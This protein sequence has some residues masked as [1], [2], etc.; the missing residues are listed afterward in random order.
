MPAGSWNYDSDIQ[1]TVPYRG[2]KD[3]STI[4]IFDTTPLSDRYFNVLEFPDRFTAGKNLFKINAANQTLVDG[5][6]IHI[7]ILDYNG[8][9]VYF[10]PLNYLEQD[11]TRVIAVYIYPNTSPG[12]ATV[13]IAGR[14]RINVFEGN[15]VIPFTD[16][17]DTTLASKVANNPNDTAFTRK[18]QRARQ[19][20]NFKDFPNLLW[21]R[22]INIAPEKFNSTEIIFT[23]QPRVTVAERIISYQTPITLNNVNVTKT[24]KESDGATVTI[25]PIPV[26]NTS[27]AGV[28]AAYD[29]FGSSVS[30]LE[31]AL[32]M[33][34]PIRSSGITISLPDFFDGGGGDVGTTA[35]PLSSPSVDIVPSSTNPVSTINEN[36]T[37]AALTTISAPANAPVANSSNAITYLTG[38][39]RLTTTNFPLSAS[40]EGGFIIIKEP[41]VKPHIGTGLDFFNSSTGPTI[42]DPTSGGAL[43]R[44]PAAADT[45]PAN[46]YARVY[47]FNPDDGNYDENDE[48]RRIGGHVIMY[49]IEVESSTQARVSQFAGPGHS[50]PSMQ[51]F[52]F[53]CW[54]TGNGTVS[55]GASYAN[56]LTA[57]NVTLNMRT[58]YDINEIKATGDFSSSHTEPLVFSMTEQSQSF[59]E[60]I[61]SDIEPAT[62]DVYKIKTSYKPAGQ[63]GDFISAGD[64]VLERVELLEDTG[65]F[66]G[67]VSVGQMFN[68]MGYFT[69]L[70]DFNEYFETI[71]GDPFMSQTFDYNE[72]I[73]MGGIHMSPDDNYDTDTKKATGIQLKAGFRPDIKKDT[74][75][76]IRFKAKCVTGI[77]D[78]DSLSYTTSQVID[79]VATSGTVQITQPRFDVYILGANDTTADHTSII[80]IGATNVYRMTEYDTDATRDADNTI[81]SKKN[82]SLGKL[83]G[84][85]EMPASFITI[86]D[87]GTAIQENSL[88]DV[89][90]SFKSTTDQKVGIAIVQRAGSFAI[91]ELGLQADAESGFSPNFTRLNIRIPSEF[92]DVPM[93][94]KFEYFD[95]LGRKADTTTSVYPITFVGD[96]TVITGTNNLISGSVFVSNQVGA[97]IELAGVR[98]GFIRAVGYD[99]FTSASRTDQPGGFL[100]YTG[101]VLP[102][103]PDNYTGVGLELVQDSGSFLRFATADNVSGK[104]AGLEVKT[105]KFFFGSDTQF[106]SGSDGNIEIRSENATLSG[107]SVSI[108][109]PEFFLGSSTQ[110]VSGAD[111]NIEIL[112]D[113]FHVEPD[114]TVTL[115]GTITAQAGG[116]IG[117]WGIGTNTLSSSNATVVLDADGPYYISSS[118]FQIDGAGAI[119]A[120]AGFVAGFTI[121]DH[122][123][124]TSGVEINDSSQA[125]FISS[126]GFKVDHAGNITASNVDLSGKIS[127]TE[128]DIGGFTIDAHSLSTTG[129][130]INDSTQTIFI[131][132]SGFKVDHSGNVTASNVDLSGKITAETGTIG[133][134]EIGADFLRQG[135]VYRIS[136]SNDTTDPAGFISSSNFKVSPSGNITGSNVLFN[137]GEIAAFEIKQTPGSSAGQIL[138][139]AQPDHP[140]PDN[141]LRRSLQ[142]FTGDSLSAIRVQS[143][144]SLTLPRTE[145]FFAS[146]DNHGFRHINADSEAIL[147]LGTQAGAASNTIA[148]WSLDADSISKVTS[149]G[150]VRID[151][152]TNQILFLTGSANDTAV[153]KLG[154]LG[155]D[156]HGILA[157][158]SDDV[159]KQILK[160]G[161]DGNQIAGWT[162]TDKQLEADNI[163]ISASGDI[164]SKNFVSSIGG[165]GAGYRISQDGI[166]EFEEARIR[167]TLSTAVFEKETVSAVGGALIVANATTLA[168]GSLILSGSGN[169]AATNGVITSVLTV[170]NASGFVAGEYLLAKATSSNGFTEEIMKIS[171]VNESSNLLAVTRSVNDNMI[172]SMSAGQV[173]VSQGKEGTGYILLNATSG[174]ETP[175]IDIVEREGAGLNDIS[176]KARLGDLSGI[177]DTSFSDNVDGFGLYTGNGYFK[178]KIEIGSR[179][180]QAPNDKLFLHYNFQGSTNNKILSQTP[181]GFTASFTGDP[182][183]LTVPG[184]VTVTGSSELQGPLS[185]NANEFTSSLPAGQNQFSAGFRLSFASESMDRNVFIARNY[186]RFVVYKQTNDRIQVRIFSGS[187]DNNVDNIEQLSFDTGVNDLIKENDLYHIFVTAKENHSASIDVYNVTSGSYVAGASAALEFANNG[188]DHTFGW[189]AEYTA[190]AYAEWEHGAPGWAGSSD[191]NFHGTWHDIRYYKDTVLTK[192]QMEAIVTNTDAAAGGTIIDGNSIQTGQ[193]QSTNF[194]TSAGSQFDL[195][196]GTFKL[197]GTDN[198]SLEFDGLNLIV[199]GA[200]SA[201]AGEIANFVIDDHSLSTTG[202]EIN[203]STQTLFISSSNFKVNHSG[204][205]TGS[206]VLFTGGKIAGFDITEDEIAKNNVTMSNA[207]GGKITLSQGSIFLS[208]S[209]EG[210]F[211]NGAIAFD[212]FGNLS[213]TDA[214]LEVSNT[215]FTSEAH[216]AA[217]GKFIDMFFD[218]DSGTQGTISLVAFEDDTII[219]RTDRTGSVIETLTLSASQVASPTVSRGGSRMGDIYDANKPMFAYNTNGAPLAPLSA[220]GQTFITKVTRDNPNLFTFFSPFGDAKVYISS[221]STNNGSFPFEE[222]NLIVSQST[223]TFKRTTPG[224]PDT[225]AHFFI[226]SSLPIVVSNRNIGTNG[227]Y[228][229]VP[230]VS[231]EIFMTPGLAAN[232][233]LSIPNQTINNIDAMFYTSN[234]PFAVHDVGDGA[235][236]DAE[237]GLPIEMIGDTYI[238]PHTLDGFTIVSVEP[239]QVEVSRA[240]GS[241]YYH[242]DTYNFS[243]S[244][245]NPQV[246]QTGGFSGGGSDIFDANSVLFKGTMPFYLRVND[247]PGTNEY[248]VLG[249]RSRQIS[250]YQNSTTIDGNRIK[251]GKIQSNTFGASEGGEVDLDA[252]TITF[253]GTSDPDFSVDAQGNVTASSALFTGNVV[254]TNLTEKFVS[255]N[256]SN[257]GSFLRDLGLG[258]GIAKQFNLVFD[259]SLGGQVC[260]NME[261]S[262]SAAFIIKDIELPF[263]GSDR[264]NVSVFINTSGMRFNDGVINQGYQSAVDNTDIIRSASD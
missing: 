14:A 23:K 212:E 262:T 228:C 93:I 217:T 144:G 94:F 264:S 256:D 42:P 257:S 59:A 115:T 103:S 116:D 138:S 172:V 219:T 90:F 147:F 213:I 170:D 161:Q 199:S 180:A 62:G 206:Q 240:S 196:N 85:V 86:N 164:V 73:Y 88:R 75:Y 96:N 64:T 92:I 123:L 34:T 49:I 45:P 198:P 193:L 55:S 215:G 130:E 249:Y 126:S 137:N 184:A 97:G 163:I 70:S 158:D 76:T 203:D 220:V 261:I 36:L 154:D 245:A 129:V 159:S 71:S 178:G 210:Q 238:V 244:K 209:G 190:S 242:Y 105:N 125:I 19:F 79:G 241:E 35:A 151:S 29:Q 2:I 67:L 143:T 78:S 226:T 224:D 37:V 202:V 28:N 258:S 102:D 239:G 30:A 52:N 84:T 187:I 25:T 60:I 168:S 250:Q 110:F 32:T 21:Q 214:R 223:L 175:Y 236:T 227:D 57:A 119:T 222:E 229:Y 156:K 27:A 53:T 112:S 204:N 99:G 251:T 108:E 54:K 63:F 81:L 6:E 232:G 80:P 68:R 253:G 7:E 33:N 132:S 142:I 95:Y 216:N 106:I 169:A 87:E 83:I 18:G 243:G 26:L 195:D 234:E 113:N 148:G 47:G 260:Q 38:E 9:P 118:G 69:G 174:S 41:K 122:S 149:N 252:G 218:D 89:A 111:G 208:G 13:Y 82:G 72:S 201:S 155:S 157:L 188:G 237:H 248:P 139:K 58:A 186:P 20:Q 46:S 74:Q 191:N 1:K 165:A 104:P 107:S 211:A 230:P 48:F 200:I 235:G 16:T 259:G 166:A 91:K 66:E 121:D 162:L 24:K 22:T 179:A 177:V 114:G 153:L 134:L 127:A 12:L 44:I 167:G 117:G 135:D 189:P 145:M 205:I 141:V 43:L 124:S 61:I 140:E 77:S 17:L 225:V 31:G 131:S 254:A 65:S 182:Y 50:A 176:V 192:N 11:G 233:I 51:G 171:G 128:G 133:G 152:S 100:M 181:N 255:V 15:R 3:I 207:N 150:G 98:S 263:T 136:S 120:S 183:I 101:S 4:E 5:S 39:S 10:E 56:Q 246:R 197:G 247:Q 221:G 185:V 231:K 8:D 40:M 173:L 160:L 109:A 146:E 194:G